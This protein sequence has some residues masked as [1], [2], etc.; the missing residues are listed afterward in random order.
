VNVA[1]RISVVVMGALLVAGSVMVSTPARV[2]ALES[3]KRPN[4]K[5]TRIRD[6]HIQLV[7]GRRLLRFTT[8]FV[9]LGQG[10]FELR[11]HRASTRDR[12]MSIDQVIY[13]TDGTTHRV[14][15]DAIAKY[16]GD[17]HD[18]WHVQNVVIYE[19]WRI[20]DLAATRRGTKTGF[21]FFDTTPWKLSLPGAPRRGYYQEEW[22]GTKSVLSN[23]VGVSVGWGDDY[24]WNF[25]FQW[26]DITGLPGGS[27]RVRATVDLRNDY[28]ETV[29]DD[30]CV[31]STIHIPNPGAGSTVTVE[32]HGWGCDEDAMRA[33]ATFAGAVTFNPRRQL[34]FEPAV[35]IGYKLNSKG[36]EL[37]RIWHHPTTQRS[38]TASARAKV[39]GRAGYWYYV[40]SGPY[41]GYWFPDNA[42]VN[43]A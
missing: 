7:D 33:V 15:T 23:R 1:R 16:A 39:P 18:H 6:W 11:G 36:T 41:A 27:Y 29:E 40:V 42:N 31:W 3:D 13:R 14:P 38:G 28:L 20:G 37:D 43:P 35:Q 8:I 25:V 12:T 5:M 9:N 21:C 34:V 24:P 32:D 19:A 10:R 30:N 2:I 22:C 4:L 17:G 26:I